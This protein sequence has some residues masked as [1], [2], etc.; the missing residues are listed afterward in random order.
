MSTA[1]IYW[2]AGYLEGEG[3]FGYKDWSPRITFQTTDFDVAH[4]AG[5][6]LGRGPRGPLQRSPSRKPIW[7]TAAYGQRAASWMM[8][9]YALLGVRRQASIRNALQRWRV[10]RNMPPRATEYVG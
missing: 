5:L 8:T 9:L 7:Y 10:S 1:D 2:L 6:L 3:S 4:H